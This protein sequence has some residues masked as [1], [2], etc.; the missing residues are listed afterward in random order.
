M[1][2]ADAFVGR[3]QLSRNIADNLSGQ[4]GTFAG[5]A[6]FLPTKSGVLTYQEEGHLQ[7]GATPP[8]FATRKYHWHFE[9][10][11]VRVT[12]EDGRPFHQFLP[13]GHAAGTDHPCGDDFYQ[14]RYD[15]TDWPHWEAVW[16]VTGPRK[17]YSSF[18]NYSQL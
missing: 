6:T 17:D 15:F 11:L 9:G 13:S 10:D 7:F 4:R 3:W 14:V 2:N 16:T 5:T 8:M 12:F 1:H 18:S